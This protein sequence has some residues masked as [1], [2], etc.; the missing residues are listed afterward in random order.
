MSLGEERGGEVFKHLV[1][2]EGAEA[3]RGDRQDQ[4]GPRE[5]VDDV[6]DRSPKVRRPQSL[7]VT[8]SG[9]Y[10]RAVLR[11]ALGDDKAALLID[12]ILQGGDIASIESLKWMDAARWP[13]C[14]ATSTRRS[15]RPSSSHLD[16]DQA[17][18]VLKLFTRAP[19]QRGH[20]AHR[21]AGR[22]PARGAAG[23][24]RGH[25]QGADRRRQRPASRPGRRED[26]GRNHQPDGLR[27]ESTSSTDPPATIRPGA[28]DHG[29]HV[30]VRRPDQARRQGIQ[31]APQ[32]S[33]VRAPGHCASRVPRPGLQRKISSDV[34]AALPRA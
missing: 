9:D 32:G 13:S 6:V 4:V 12:R 23:P 29:Q 7:L 31:T 21:H 27:H 16:P 14:C 28:E 15:S 5:R 24:E 25:E 17:A 30:R 20:G 19:A 22:H 3:G 34:D 10:V 26:R 2:S 1:P 8:D 11:R 18:E 33:G